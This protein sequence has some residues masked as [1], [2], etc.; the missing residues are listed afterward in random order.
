MSD[1]TCGFRAMTV[2]GYDKIKPYLVDSGYNLEV[3]ML[4]GVHRQKLSYKVIK[5]KTVYLDKYKGT[6]IFDGIKMVA[7]MT[8]R[9]IVLW[10]EDIVE[11]YG[12]QCWRFNV[13]MSRY[14]LEK[15]YYPYLCENHRRIV[16]K[17][18][19]IPIIGGISKHW[20]IRKV[21]R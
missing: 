13:F 10:T 3:D 11:W 2:E 8:F 7:H 19:Y 6:D 18:A 20:S 16:S 9:K 21:R 14:A 4:I 1:I 12:K 17:Y 15:G 5:I